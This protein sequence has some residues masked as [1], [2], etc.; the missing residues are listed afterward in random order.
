MA[1]DAPHF[2]ARTLTAAKLLRTSVALH[3]AVGYAPS[4][5]PDCAGSPDALRQA[6]A[7]ELGSDRR[8]QGARRP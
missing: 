2:P 1:L 6:R 4:P 5:Q 8:K 3:L 7:P